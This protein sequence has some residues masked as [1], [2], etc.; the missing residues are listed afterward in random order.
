MN[1]DENNWLRE[2]V[3]SLLALLWSVATI[4]ILYAALFKDIRSDEKLTYVVVT[5]VVNIVLLILGFYYVSSKLSHDRSKAEFEMKKIQ[6]EKTETQSIKTEIKTEPL[7][8]NNTN[9]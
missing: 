3:T 8:S 4:G 2:N 6:E 7:I 9:P 1:K 5:S